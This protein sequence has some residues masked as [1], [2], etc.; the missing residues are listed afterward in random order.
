MNSLAGPSRIKSFTLLAPA[1]LFWRMLARQKLQSAIRRIDGCSKSKV[2]ILTEN[3][4]AKTSQSPIA[5]VV[6]FPRPVTE[7][8]LKEVHRLAWNFAR[9]P[10]LI[11]IDPVAIRSWSCCE[12]PEAAE[13]MFSR[14]EISDARINLVDAQEL[15]AHA[16][17]WTSLVSGDFFREPGR[18]SYFDRDK[19][20]DRLLLDNLSEVRRQLHAGVSGGRESLGYPTIHALL[21]RLMFLQFLADRRDTDGNAAL[22]PDFFV[23]RQRDGTLTKT[24]ETIADVL[25]SKADTYR[26]FHWLN[27]KFNGDLFPTEQEQRA[28]ERVVHVDHLKFFTRFIRG[29]VELRKGQRLLWRQYSFDVIPLEFISSIYEEFIR[30][31]D[32]EPGKGVV[33]TPPH[34]V[35]FILDGVLPWDGKQWDMTVLDPAC[36]SGIFLVKAYQ[37]LVHRWKKK[38]PEQRPTAGVLR[39]ILEKCLFGV[40]TEDDAVGVASFSLYL[41]MCDEI[42]PKRYWTNVR[43]PKLRGQTI[44]CQDFFDDGPTLKQGDR[45]REFDLIVGNPPWGQEE[46]L[47]AA[48]T[49]WV[50]RETE[51]WPAADKR[52]WGTSY[53]NIGPLFLPRAAEMLAPDGRSSLMQS[54]AVLLNDVSTAREFRARLLLEYLVEEIVNLSPLRYTLFSNAS[55]ATSP[56]AVIT[57]RRRIS[58]RA[59]D[60]FV[61]MCPKPMQSVEDDYRLMIGPHDVHSVRTKE[62]LTGRNVLTTLLWG[63][64][65]Y[66][67]LLSK[68][69]LLPTL[70]AQKKQSKVISREGIIRGDR[71]R[72]QKAIM[73]RP[74]L[75]KPNFPDSVFLILDP[76]TMPTNTDSATDSRDSTN[77]DAFDAPQL[78]IKLSWTRA[79]GRFRAA[80]VQSSSGTGVICSQA[81]VSVHTRVEDEGLLDSA[82][83]VYNSNFALYWLYLTNHRL[84]SFI[85][86]ATVSDLLL[87]PLPVLRPHEIDTIGDFDFGAVD[88]RVK[89]ALGLEDTDWALISDFFTYTLPDR[90]HASKSP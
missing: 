3:P 87:L 71:K 59:G 44:S 31:G 81:Y 21:A 36:G 84:A 20:A 69:S 14:I 54:S 85:S 12:P 46:E 23:Q 17:S 72:I 73:D 57:F 7:T 48:A 1:P 27:T 68:L 64:R 9:S 63:G 50:K 28:E 89:Q 67:A 79:N 86:E 80:R 39:Q 77:F 8:A 60:E 30:N 11:T 15:A 4:N 42:D 45:L 38:N 18:T 37:R 61:Y 53:V 65:R 66:L 19:A 26:L 16:L 62:V 40:D 6:E 74:I 51:R 35:D 43:F 88:E 52:T 78:V 76:G 83:L 49:A 29:D 25:E 33:Y 5:V 13:A 70:Q 47:S 82:C 58:D 32:T 41:A 90:A 22:N 75:E 56:P 34:L 10:L 55:K 24:Y 2:G